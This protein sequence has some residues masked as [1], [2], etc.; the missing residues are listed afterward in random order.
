ML[1]F[2][3]EIREFAF[4][5]ATL[6]TARQRADYSLKDRYSQFDANAAIKMAHDAIG[7]LKKV[8]TKD[9]RGCVS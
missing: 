8:G 6:Q 7:A 1:K 2:P 9:R 3:L 5:F 4:A